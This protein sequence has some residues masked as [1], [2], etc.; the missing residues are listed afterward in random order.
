[1]YATN[2]LEKE[3]FLKLIAI[4]KLLLAFNP[5]HLE[6]VNP[7]VMGITRAELDK[8][9]I[10]NKHDVLPVT[11]HGDAS[12]IA[13]GVIQETLNMCNTPAHTVGGTLRIVINN[14]IGFTTDIKD[15]RSTRY[16]TDIAKMIQAPIFHVNGDH[17]YAV[18][19]A[20]RLAL[21]FRNKFYR[22]IIIDLVCYRRHG[23]NEADEPGV[24]QPIMYQKIKKHPTLKK[25]F[26][27]LL[28]NEKV[29]STK[30]II[31][32]TNNIRKKLNNS[33]NMVEIIQKLK[34]NQE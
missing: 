14:Q 24:T 9:N 4:I 7:V 2:S 28:E 6:I 26:S 27:N 1:M 23:H 19:F 32:I 17:P 20:T 29:I 21:D 22:D 12:I 10:Q 18:I 31:E 8:N 13:Q 3:I 25:I 30:E 5:S 33:T 11:I 34:C 16:C 15:A